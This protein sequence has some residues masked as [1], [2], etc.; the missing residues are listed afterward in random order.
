MVG[1]IL[2]IFIIAIYFYLWYKNYHFK[3]STITFFQGAVGSGKTALMT[4]LALV[5]RN[6]RVLFNRSLY[7]VIKYGLFFIKKCRKIEKKSEKIY[8]TYPIFID[9]S[10]WNWTYKVDIGS[11]IVSD[12]M[13]Y[14]MPSK[15]EK[16][17]PREIFTLT[18]IRHATNACILASSQNI[19]E[20]LKSFRMKTTKCYIL[21]SCR[22]ALPIPFF[23]NSKVNVKEIF[24]VENVNNV[25]NNTDRKFD[26]C[27][28][29]FI[30]PK[31]N[32]DSRYG[33]NFYKL[34]D[35]DIEF[36]SLSYDNLLKKMNLK[37]GDKWKGLCYEFMES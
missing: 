16:A 3:F 26:P 24:N 31:K 5:E 22:R 10:F 12:E 25:I 36:L 18:W 19:E 29:N 27:V 7:Y 2:I 17:N 35:F 28:Y 33:R 6:R 1:F 30:Y 15:N 8:S 37:C 11:I 23:R 32:F 13:A 9:K 34:K 4:K 21:D 14:L 20:C